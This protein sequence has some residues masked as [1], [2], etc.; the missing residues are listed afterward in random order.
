MEK[1]TANHTKE[2]FY[3]DMIAKNEACFPA[4]NVVQEL[5]PLL[6]EYFLGSFLARGDAIKLL[7][8]NGQEFI[9]T[10]SEINA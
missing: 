4:L 6:E 8:P 7:F 2:K 5:T 1:Q 9:L 10:V 3:D